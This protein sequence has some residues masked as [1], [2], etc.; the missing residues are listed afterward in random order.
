[1]E[2]SMND[3]AFVK[4]VFWGLMAFVVVAFLYARR[5]RR[6][7]TH[8]RLPTQTPDLSGLPMTYTADNVVAHR[9]EHVWWKDEDGGFHCQAF[10]V[11]RIYPD[12]QL[13]I[14]VYPEAGPWQNQGDWIF[15]GWTYS[16]PRDKRITPRDL[17]QHEFGIALA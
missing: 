16:I 6:T 9:I 17:S 11:R 3:F 12:G 10:L 7:S 5:Q 4:L 2:D 1:M 13:L 8:A 14:G 15:S